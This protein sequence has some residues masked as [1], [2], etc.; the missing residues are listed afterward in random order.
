MFLNMSSDL[1]K[2]GYLSPI[3]GLPMDTQ[4]EM[5]RDAGIPE[6]TTYRRGEVGRNRLARDYWIRSLREG[7][8]AWVPDIRVLILPR[9]DRAGKRP[10][11]DLAA[12]I[13]AV[14]SKGAVLVDHKAGLNSKSAGWQA[15]VEEAINSVAQVH[16]TQEKV[17]SAAAIARAKRRQGMVARWKAPSMKAERER[18]AAV[19]RDPVYPNAEAAIAALPDELRGMSKPT[20]ERIFGRRR[21]G[22]PKAGGR[23]K[24]RKR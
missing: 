17:D 10:G 12:A 23:G 3:R 13:I 6:K 24:R 2:R 4:E 19:Y 14:I 8:V 20:I 7:D 22:D 15:H 16:R 11:A 5:A 9:H 21:P 18:W 1:H